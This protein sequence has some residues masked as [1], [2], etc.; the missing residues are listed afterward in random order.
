[1]QLSIF[2]YQSPE[3]QQFAEI[4]TV[5][6]DGE[7]WFVAA[8]VCKTLE[9][10]NAPDAVSRLDDDEK[11]LSVLPIAGQNRIGTTF[12]NQKLKDYA[13]SSNRQRPCK[14]RNIQ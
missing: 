6:I 5:E 7:I 1:M 11:L 4:R 9:I 12:I 2:K 13:K 3:E 8:D 14:N 10:K